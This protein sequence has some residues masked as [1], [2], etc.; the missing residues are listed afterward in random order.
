MV[1]GQGGIACR[2][3]SMD[4]RSALCVRGCVCGKGARGET[5]LPG[6][7]LHR[8]SVLSPEKFKEDLIGI[9]VGR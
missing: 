9:E 7:W 6:F 8:V 5:V 1:G 2:T 4:R 3:R